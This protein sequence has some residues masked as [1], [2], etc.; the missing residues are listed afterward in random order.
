M[1]ETAIPFRT[2]GDPPADGQGRSHQGK[3]LVAGAVEVTDGGP[4]RIRLRAI[5]DF[6]GDTLAGVV[7]DTVAS[8][9]AIK[10]DGWTGNAACDDVVH[11]SNV[12]SSMAVHIVLP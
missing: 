3:M 7:K 5:P 1:D 12:I 10:T 8:G 2:H 9:F 6:S 11:D 4:G